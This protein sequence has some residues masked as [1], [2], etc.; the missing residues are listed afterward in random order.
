MKFMF[1]FRTVHVLILAYQRTGSS[2]LG[3][4]Y[5]QH[6]A[7]FYWYEPIDGIYASLYG[8]KHGWTVPSDI[9]TNKDGSQ[10]Y[11][12]EKEKYIFTWSI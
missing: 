7:T 10:R 6:D 5:N 1:V 12:L 2:F 11:T 8:T 3:E 9:Y 4:L